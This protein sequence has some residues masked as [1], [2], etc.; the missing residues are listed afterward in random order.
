MDSRKYFVKQVADTIQ[1]NHSKDKN[2][3]FIFGISGKW[4]EG[5]THFLDELQKELEETEN[6]SGKFKVFT[7]NPWKFA[8]DSDNTSF[9]RNFLKTLSKGLGESCSVESDLKGLDF[10]TSE[11][12]VKWEGFNWFIIDLLIWGK[13]FYSLN[14][15]S[16]EFHTFVVGWKPI[17]TLVLIPIFLAIIGKFF[18]IQ[19]SNHAIST[20]DQFDDLLIKIIEAFSEEKKKIVVFVDDLDRVTPEV[21][22]D[23]LDNLRTFF[24]KPNISFVV[25]GDHTVLERYL[26]NDLLPKGDSPERS[27]EGRRFLK[28][29]FN[30]YWRLPLPLDK[31]VENF[32]IEK[33]KENSPGLEKIFPKESDRLILASYL[34]KFFGKNYRQIIRFID[35][36]LFTFEVIHRKLEDCEDTEKKYLQE[37]ADRPLLVVRILMI[38]ELCAPLFDR[39]LD[40]QKILRDLEYAVEKKETVKINTII[41]IY[42]SELS[43]TQSGFI[44]SFLYEE[45]RFY[46]G[47]SW[48]VSDIRTFLFLAADSSFSDQRGMSAEDFTNTLV[49]GDPAEIKEV[50]SSS[51]DKNLDADAQVVIEQLPGILDV[52]TRGSQLK[53][54]TMA[55]SELPTEYSVHKIF[56]N[57]LKAL[58]MSFLNSIPSPQKSDIINSF[59]HWLDVANDP[60]IL[61]EYETKFTFGNVADVDTLILN[62]N[63]LFTSHIITNWLKSFYT[64]N[65]SDSLDRMISLFPEI[66]IDKV[67]ENMESI[68]ETLVNDLVTQND[69][70]REKRFDII[71]NYTTNGLKNLKE[72]VFEQINLLNPNITQWAFSKV[73]L[74]EVWEK[75]ELEEQITKRLKNSLDFASLTQG[76]NFVVTEKNIDFE[77]AWKEILSHTKFISDNIP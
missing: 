68:E 15:L 19:R 13:F 48:T 24:D 60:L 16:S 26:G 67:K 23:V 21:A 50:L 61:N 39:I 5:K 4:G 40:E 6:D 64:S 34:K 38:Q 66:K 14:N 62:K 8:S 45:P 69:N 46:K 52:L 47:S 41:D 42:K 59:W 54:V 49:T 73:G 2:G 74:K 32:V 63:G 22:H 70:L 58:D 44:K 75:T 56:T 43:P 37:L 1:K 30:V 57:K 28:K 9:L 35:T 33:F 25:T 7:I 29:I 10:D 53:A 18:T 31:E 27:E 20:I 55:L 51:G 76:I 11:T 12:M 36:T 77:K 3:S 72:K 65:P 17:I 71:K